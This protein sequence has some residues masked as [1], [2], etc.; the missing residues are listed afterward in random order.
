[1][2]FILYE[3]PL[4][5]DQTHNNKFSTYFWADAAGRASKRNT[6]TH[7][8]YDSNI[9]LSYALAPWCEIYK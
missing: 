7:L 1:M 6:E 9:Y 8:D 3:G 4:S 2:V 5:V